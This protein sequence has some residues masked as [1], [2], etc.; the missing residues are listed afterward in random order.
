MKI[1]LFFQSSVGKKFLMAMSGLL[2]CGFLVGHLSGNLLLYVGKQEF[3]DYSS[4][5]TS[6][7]LIYVVEAILVGALLIHVFTAIALVRD[8]KKARGSSYKSLNLKG[9][10]SMTSTY[11]G[12]SGLLILAFLILHIYT[13]KFGAWN[14]Q[15]TSTLYDLVLLRFAD[16]WYAGIYVFCMICMGIHL[17][18][19]FKSAFHTL[20]LLPQTN[21][22]LIRVSSIFALVMTIG[23][24]S[25]PVYFYY[26]QNFIF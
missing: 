20:G 13:F 19:A 16:A 12:L 17:K 6:T 24:G 7:S 21:K 8:N 18:H 14:N 23:F 4:L 2:Y 15:T 9:N 3:N 22:I 10:S 11:M 5:L 1:N 25:F 26:T